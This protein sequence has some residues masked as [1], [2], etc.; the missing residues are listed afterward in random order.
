MAFELKQYQT[1]CL[2]EL[3]RFFVRAGAVGAAAGGH[4]QADVGQLARRC[5][6]T[7]RS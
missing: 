4:A 5:A 1:R 7:R 2:E 3:E 6:V